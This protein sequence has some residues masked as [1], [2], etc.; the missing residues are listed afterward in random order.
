MGGVPIRRGLA[1][2]VG[3]VAW[4][5]VVLATVIMIAVYLVPHSLRGSQLDYEKLDAGRP[6]SDSVTTGR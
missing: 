1:Q 3:L 5:S 2:D 4:T 6:A